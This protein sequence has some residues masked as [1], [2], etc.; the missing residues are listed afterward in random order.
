MCNIVLIPI[1]N[2]VIF[3]LFLI[4]EFFFKK[5]TLIIMSKSTQNPKGTAFIN[6]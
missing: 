1:Y 3:Y 6:N 5:K 4:P 2:K